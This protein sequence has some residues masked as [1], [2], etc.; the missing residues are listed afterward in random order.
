M[1]GIERV[2]FQVSSGAT[3]AA[4]Q[5]TVWTHSQPFP[6]SY[7]GTVDGNGLPQNYMKYRAMERRHYVDPVG[8]CQ[9]GAYAAHPHLQAAAQFRTHPYEWINR[10]THQE[11]IK[12]R[13]GLLLSYPVNR[14]IKTAFEIVVT[15]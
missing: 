14:K 12:S 5:C 4:V 3:A 2:F 9:Q 15:A 8:G 10:N 13:P 6:Y 11:S 7:P 1:I